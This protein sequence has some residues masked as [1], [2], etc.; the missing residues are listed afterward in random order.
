MRSSL[1]IYGACFAAALLSTGAVAQEGQARA[2]FPASFFSDAN[3]QNA[4]D[5][6]ERVPGFTL[7]EGSEVR[8][9]GDAA[10]NVLV[11][12]VRPPSKD[13][14]LVEYL[15]RIPAASVVRIDL[16]DG[17]VVGLDAGGSL[18]VANIV[19]AASDSSSGT[20]RINGEGVG[21]GRVGGSATATWQGSFRGASLS[22]SVQGGRSGLELLEGQEMLFSGDGSLIEEGPLRDRR[23]ED[24]FAGSLLASGR[25][26][27]LDT[28][29]SGSIRTYAWGRFSENHLVAGGLLTR[30]RTDVEAQNY[31]RRASEVS[32]QLSKAFDRHEIRFNALRNTSDVS[33]S[34]G[35]EI[36]RTASDFDS[37]LFISDSDQTEDILR[38]SW[39]FKSNDWSTQFALESVRTSLSAD[40]AFRRTVSSISQPV[41]SEFTQVGEVRGSAAFSATYSGLPGF[42]IVAGLAS[43]NSRISL[44]SPL[45]S[46][47]TYQFLKPRL[48]ISWA[49]SSKMTLSLSA[50]R[51][52]GQLDFSDFVGAQQVGDGSST[53]T[54]ADLQPPQTD[55]FRLAVERRWGESGSLGLTLV[56]EQW[57]NLVDVVPV[58]LGQGVGNI[59]EAESYGFDI[60]V[61]W[62]VD[63][64]L[65][66]AE[67]KLAGAWRDTSVRD[68]FN[69]R[70]R[71]PQ[72][73]EHDRT[74]L[75]LRHVLSRTL[76]YGGSYVYTPP[77]R[78]FRRDQFIEFL[79]GESM[80]V[81]GELTLREGLKLR[82]EINYIGGQDL[83]RSLIRYAGIRELADVSSVEIRERIGRSSL[84]IQLASTF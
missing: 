61:T 33:D 2:T 70:S 8:G 31:D 32:L 73:L 66:G 76:T 47:N 80:N 15:E 26:L 46:S 52:V 54:N 41:E 67:L 23:A 35:I 11:N 6:L 21:D 4:L 51:S 24:T 7:V 81:Y 25:I 37:S 50:E 58:D 59:P 27:G 74:T 65:P 18:L 49:A 77:R 55:A 68:P 43:E 44:T 14:S 17:A 53:Q 63:F 72:M 38:L 40:S 79:E 83:D 71:P 22:A 56:R 1:F 57:K 30:P 84:A 9:F 3:P 34:S 36:R 64:V 60:E 13:V 78:I 69:G 16:L 29:L 75:S 48:S 45:N 10:G 82:A 39:E 42:I 62:P 12:G 20:L 28:I 19:L 5:L